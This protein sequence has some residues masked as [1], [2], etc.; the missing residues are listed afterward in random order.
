MSGVQHTAKQIV[1]ILRVWGLVTCTCIIHVLVHNTKPSRHATQLL[2]RMRLC[3]ALQYLVHCQS[4]CKPAT[5][6]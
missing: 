3:G 1:N 6:W 5:P 2:Y 4:S